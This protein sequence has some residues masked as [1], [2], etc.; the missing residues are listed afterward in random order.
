MKYSTPQVQP[1]GVASTLIQFK[2]LPKTDGNI[3]GHVA[4]IGNLLEK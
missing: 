3:S 1:V 4:A 2:P